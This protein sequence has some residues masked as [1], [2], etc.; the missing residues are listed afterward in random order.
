L[1]LAIIIASP[2]AWYIMHLRLQD[3]AI[4]SISA[5]GYFISRFAYA[6]AIVGNRFPDGTSAIANP[7][8]SLRTEQKHH[9]AFRQDRCFHQPF[10][11]AR[12]GHGI[13]LLSSSGA[14]F[15][16]TRVSKTMIWN[17]CR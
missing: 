11:A 8:N 13:W 10:P 2:V 3:F 4:V 1:L 9:Y 12:R 14:L 7:A 6:I 15:A 16:R 5:G 17:L